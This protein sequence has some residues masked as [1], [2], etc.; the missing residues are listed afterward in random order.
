MSGVSARNELTVDV[1][2][3]TTSW[4]NPSVMRWMES[5]WSCII[6]PFPSFF[7]SVSSHRRENLSLYFSTTTVVDKHK[8]LQL[9]RRPTTM[10]TTLYVLLLALAAKLGLV[11]VAT[12][13]PVLKPPLQ[14][15]WTIPKQEGNRVPDVDFLTR[16]RI[17]DPAEEFGWKTRT[18]ADYFAGK[19]IVLFSLPGAF[20]PTCSATHLPGYQDK[21]DEILKLGIDDV[22][23]KLIVYCSCGAFLW[24]PSSVGMC[25][26][27]AWLIIKTNGASVGAVEHPCRF[28][29]VG[30]SILL[31]LGHNG[32]RLSPLL[33]VL[34]AVLAHPIVHLSLVLYRFVGQ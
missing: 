9:Y 10:K 19:R 15:E 5:L 33:H 3:I 8:A 13:E 17:D 18:T 32:L 34:F 30:M 20:T 26:R 27:C 4:E 1:S 2:Q 23:C 29:R 25:V 16:T 7:R 21:Y 14:K 31:P 22:Y 6:R 24:L 11:V 28:I 12:A